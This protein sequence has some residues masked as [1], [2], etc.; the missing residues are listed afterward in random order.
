M[1]LFFTFIFAAV[2]LAG[3]SKKADV[4]PRNND[5]D[6]TG[7]PPP[8]A[9]VVL[10][11]DDSI[12]MPK[13]YINPQ[14]VK[15]SVSGSKLTLI[16]NENVDILFSAEAYQRISAVHL[17]EDFKATLLNGLDFTTVAE[18]GNTTADWVDD[19]LN[20]VRLKRITDTVVN[21]LKMVKININRPFTFFK[22]YPSNKE[23]I[24]AQAVFISKTDDTM[25]FTSFS[26][27]NQKI[28]LPQ[29]EAALLVYTK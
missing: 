11:H 2:I 28:Y 22:S 29:S 25:V 1:K 10:S 26:Y 9:T 4:S 3:C 18:G 16:F 24:D 21:S 13:F 5:N 15:T 6:I 23:A 7:T 19:N 12:H 8:D 14:T 17:T 20:N 27:Y